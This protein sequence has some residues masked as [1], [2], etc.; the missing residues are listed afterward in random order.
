MRRLAAARPNLGRVGRDYDLLPSEAAI[1]ASEGAV[2]IAATTAL[3]AAFDGGEIACRAP[4]LAVGAP[5]RRRAEAL[6]FA[7]VA[8]TKVGTN[9]AI[10]TQS[11]RR[12]T[13]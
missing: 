5:D 4:I 2:S 11:R 9:A 10:A 7:A 1:D 12:P 13:R 6:A 8:R 3:R